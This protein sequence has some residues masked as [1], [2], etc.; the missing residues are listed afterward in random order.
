MAYNEILLLLDLDKA[1]IRMLFVSDAKARNASIEIWAIKAFI[2]I[3]ANSGIAKIA[4]SKMDDRFLSGRRSRCSCWRYALIFPFTMP[5]EY[6]VHNDSPGFVDLKK[7]VE[8]IVN[9]R[10]PG[11]YTRSA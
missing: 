8:R 6:G 5:T 9:F 1:M 3:T 2:T 4:V 11:R 10:N 7:F